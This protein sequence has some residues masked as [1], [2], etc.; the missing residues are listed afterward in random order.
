MLKPLAAARNK[1]AD[2]HSLTDGI[3]GDLFA[4]GTILAPENKPQFFSGKDW[5]D[6]YDWRRR[7]CQSFEAYMEP[8][9]QR[10]T[11]LQT[12]SQAQP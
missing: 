1:L 7:Y 5:D 6:D 2:Y 4:I 11:N 12:L 8:Y 9:K 3:H 10:I